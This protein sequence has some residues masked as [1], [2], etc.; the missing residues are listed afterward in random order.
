[1]KHIIFACVGGLMIG[2]ETDNNTVLYSN[3]M[4]IVSNSTILICDQEVFDEYTKS[5]PLN[6]VNKKGMVYLDETSYVYE[7]QEPYIQAVRVNV[8]NYDIYLDPERG[9]YFFMLYR[10]GLP[11]NKEQIEIHI[12]DNSYDK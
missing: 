9:N 3:D 5:N 4:D 2:S 8:G 10:G 7:S 11:K 1:M 6:R 12:K